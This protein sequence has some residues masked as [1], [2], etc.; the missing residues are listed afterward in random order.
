MGALS[1]WAMLAVTHHVIVQLAAFRSGWKGWYPLYALLGDDIVILRQDVATEY[2]SLMR[3]LGVPINMSKTIQSSTGLLEFAKRVVSA[4]H[5]DL[6]PISGRLL[7]T[8]VRSPGAY[9][10]LWVHILDFGFILFPNQLL[11]VIANLSSDVN[12]KPFTAIDSPWIGIAVIARVFMLS[13]IREGV[14]LRPRFV[15]EWYRAILGDAVYGPLLDK[16]VRGTEFVK[17][18]LSRKTEN[19]RAWSELKLFTTSWWRFALFS[20]T[21]GGVLSI[22][23]LMLSPAFWVS[24]ATRLQ[25]VWETRQADLSVS[26]NY[27][28]HLPETPVP[29]SGTD[30]MEVDIEEVNIPQLYMVRAP[31]VDVKTTLQFWVDVVDQVRLYTD[32]SAPHLPME[33][34]ATVELRLLAAPTSL[35]LATGV[36]EMQAARLE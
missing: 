13:R 35:P 33:R 15:D 23:L 34:S 5:G 12:R 10:D 27:T 14:V 20:G 11:K 4:H 8:A 17:F 18:S 9:L 22:P 6:S 1:S 19:R 29:Y 31:V 30:I 7:V 21:L 2:L 16:V 36:G 26:A 32:L 28:L 25:A 3:Y 24:L